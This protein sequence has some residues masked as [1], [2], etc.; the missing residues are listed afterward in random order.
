MSE[1]G[2]NIDVS[3]LS[4]RPRWWVPTALMWVSIGVFAVGT[5]VSV[6]EAMSSYDHAAADPERSASASLLAAVFQFVWYFVSNCFWAILVICVGRGIDKLDE[7]VWLAAS[8]SDRREIARRRRRSA[9]S[10]NW[11]RAE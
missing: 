6:G 10:G 1:V 8:E 5:L 4:S 3:S 9:Y 2:E 11:Q 7:L